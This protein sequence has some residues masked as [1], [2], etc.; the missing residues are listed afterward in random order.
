VQ[1]FSEV[2][3]LFRDLLSYSINLYVL[4]GFWEKFCIRGKE[5]G[6]SWRLYSVGEWELMM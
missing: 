4:I 3:A 6:L 5:D 2:M 1:V